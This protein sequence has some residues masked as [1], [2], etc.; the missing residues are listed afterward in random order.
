MAVSFHGHFFSY[1]VPWVVFEHVP[2]TEDF[3]ADSLDK[4]TLNTLMI[5]GDNTANAIKHE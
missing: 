2:Y 4:H 5:L 1:W 3:S